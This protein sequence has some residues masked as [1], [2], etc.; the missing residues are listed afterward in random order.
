DWFGLLNRGHFLTPLGASDSHD[1]SRFII[2]QGR[3][4]IRS[5]AK[6][7]GAIDVEEAVMSLREG[8]VLV[9]C[10]L[11]TEITVNDRY[12]PGDLVPAKGDVKVAVRVR[13]PGWTT[14]ERVELYANGI[15]IREA[16]IKDG[17]K[18]GVKWSGEWVLPS[19]R[20]DV[21]LVAVATG[22]GRGSLPG[23]IAKPYQPTSPVAE[24]RVIGST[25]AVWLDAD[26]DGQR[27]SAHGYAERVL[28]DAGGD[29]RKGIAAL[30]EYD[31]GVAAQAAALLRV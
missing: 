16:I 7:P 22:P 19:F 28:R 31:E 10:G 26:G 21:F 8:R 14:A 17:G 27:T 9:S 6:Q 1:V 15:K 24:P 20:H 13:G 18:A 29:W 12:G 4:Y 3:T 5:K 25:G 30:S 23:P 11:L 2:G